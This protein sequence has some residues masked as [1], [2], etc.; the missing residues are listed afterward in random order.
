MQVYTWCTPCRCTPLV[1]T[2]SRGLTV[3]NCC[4]SVRGRVRAFETS[5]ECAR[6]LTVENCESVSSVRGRVRAMVERSDS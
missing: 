2:R 1:Y 3:E 6:G 4:C 5:V